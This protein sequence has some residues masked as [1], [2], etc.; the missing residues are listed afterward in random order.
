MKEKATKSY[1]QLK[2]KPFDWNRFL[3]HAI[4]K[5]EPTQREWRKAV[6]LAQSWVTCACG[7]QC[8][9]LPREKDGEPVD[10]ELSQLGLEFAWNIQS[11]EWTYAYKILQKIEKLSAKLIQKRIDDSKNL[12]ISLGYKITLN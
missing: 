7:N 8:S 11:K 12:L 1:A 4:N 10:Q 5:K 6:S 9:I 3:D 2:K